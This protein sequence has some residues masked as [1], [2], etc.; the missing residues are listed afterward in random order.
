MDGSMIAILALALALVWDLL[1]GEYPRP[2]HPVVWLGK[3]IAWLDKASPAQGQWKQTMYGTGIVLIAVGLFAL[4]A[5]LLLRL[6]QEGPWWGYLL[7]SV[8]LLKP[9]FA[10]RELVQA[11]GRV[12]EQLLRGNLAEARTSVKSL[13]G[14]DTQSLD[15]PLIVS[16]AVESV[17]ENASDSLVAPLF[18]YALFGVPGA[19]AY[20]AINTMDNMIGY[21]GR[22][23]YLGKVAARLDDLANF[24]PARLTALLLI[25]ASF[26]SGKGAGALRVALRDHGRPRSPN[27]G[28]PMSAMAGALGVELVKREHYRLGVAQAPLTPARIDTACRLFLGTAAFMVLLIFLTEALRYVLFA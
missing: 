9:T 2:L 26:L 11:A 14:R 6:L 3:L 24:I 7:G 23:E 1:L 28:W 12:K 13:V 8:L 15:E 27:G 19:L 5:W 10:L 22:Y 17:A 4:P 21:H 25:A 20:R 18:Y 16:A